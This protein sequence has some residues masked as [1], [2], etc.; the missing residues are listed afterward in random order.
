[1]FLA[2]LASPLNYTRFFYPHLQP[3]KTTLLFIHQAINSSNHA[4]TILVTKSPNFALLI[5]VQVTFN[6]FAN[7]KY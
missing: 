7:I 6:M 1:M 5:K 3:F 4:S 2:F